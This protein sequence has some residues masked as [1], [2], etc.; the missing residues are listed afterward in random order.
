VLRAVARSTDPEKLERMTDLTTLTAEERRGILEDYLDAVFRDQPSPAVDRLRMGAPELP[1]DPTADQ[2]AAWVEL[3]ELL[4]DPDYVAA[5]RRMAVDP[6]PKRTRTS[7]RLSRTRPST[8]RINC[9]IRPDRAAA[10]KS[11]GRVH[12][13]DALDD[14]DVVTDVVTSRRVTRV[15]GVAAPPGRSASARPAPP[16]RA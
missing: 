7:T 4:R 15:P 10:S 6:A 16:R 1:E 9:Q 13:M 8:W 5:G 2:V 11:Y 14:L 12:D 3:A